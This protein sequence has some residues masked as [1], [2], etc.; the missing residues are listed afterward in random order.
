MK[1]TLYYIYNV[2]DPQVFW[3]IHPD[4]RVTCAANFSNSIE[5]ANKPESFYND[6]SMRA[7]TK[8]EAKSLFPKAFK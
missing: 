2:D 4:N 7:I 8:R 6:P 5:S 1:R 3:A